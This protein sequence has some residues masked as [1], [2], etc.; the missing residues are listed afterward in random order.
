[1][2]R[3]EGHEEEQ[4]RVRVEVEPIGRELREGED[5]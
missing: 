2:R 4:V 1:M 5:S 3:K